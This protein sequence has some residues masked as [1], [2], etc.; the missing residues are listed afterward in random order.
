LTIRK[1]DF[2]NS[3]LIIATGI[4]QF[5]GTPVFFKVIEEPAFWFFNGGIT[6]VLLGYLNIL[7][8]KYGTKTMEIWKLSLYSN[9][10]VLLFW[11]SM[12][13]FLFY[14]FIRYPFALIPLIFLVG[15]V[16]FSQKRY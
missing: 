1:F 14:K 12:V 15:A 8:I 4:L 10:F 5:I 2:Y 7:R 3:Y 13:Y 16:I 9:I 6:L 11:L